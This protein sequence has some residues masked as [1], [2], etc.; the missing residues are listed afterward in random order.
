MNSFNDCFSL[1]V[2]LPPPFSFLCCFYRPFALSFLLLISL[3]PCPSIVIGGVVDSYIRHLNRAWRHASS[4]S[5]LR[6]SL[7]FQLCLFG[8][9]LAWCLFFV[10]GPNWLL[11][12][13]RI[14]CPDPT[15]SARILP[16][17]WLESRVRFSGTGLVIEPSHDRET[18]RIELWSR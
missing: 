18:S 16:V 5:G 7:S 2:S 12:L 15:Q 13:D 3:F 8:L 11:G 1:A 9:S 4:N 17:Y 10:F 6:R 14:S